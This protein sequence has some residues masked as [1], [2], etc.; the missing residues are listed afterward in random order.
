[1]ATSNFSRSRSGI[2]N[3]PIE[4]DVRGFRLNADLIKAS[5]FRLA[6]Q[7]GDMR[8][9]L[10]T[11][12][13]KV[14]IPSMDK[15]FMV[16]G[17]PRWPPVD[18][19]TLYRKF[20]TPSEYNAA[21]TLIKTGRMYETIAAGFYWKIDRDKADMEQLDRVIPYAKFHQSG[22]RKMPQRQFAL[23]QQQDIERIVVIFDSWISVMT[24][25]R[26]FWPYPTNEF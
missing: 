1:V 15:N 12:V 19:E 6:R 26:D 5:T 11:A 3:F 14:I 13:T 10:K 18:T 21:L 9:P 7:L 8:V 16:Q 4:I 23:L 2:S 22:T 20:L 25:Q 24:S 17:R